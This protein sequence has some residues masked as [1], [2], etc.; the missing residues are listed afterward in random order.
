[1]NATPGWSCQTGAGGAVEPSLCW[2]EKL[3]QLTVVTNPHP[4]QLQSQL[5][6][7]FTKPLGVQHSSSAPLQV[8]P[9]CNLCKF[10]EI[11]TFP[12]V[13]L[14]WQIH[15]IRV[16]VREFKLQLTWQCQITQDYNTLVC[17]NILLN[18][19]YECNLC[20]FKELCIFPSVAL[21][22]Q[23]SQLRFHRLFIEKYYKLPDKPL[24]TLNNTP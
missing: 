2:H 16:R 6:W 24:Q 11:C 1:M 15:I 22:W 20:K 12:S 10:K 13:A 5:S 23:V 4:Q 14:L 19:T 3:A 7:G 9:W 17:R 8:Q 18:I 21:L